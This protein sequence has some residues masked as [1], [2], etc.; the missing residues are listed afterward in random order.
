MPD[1]PASRPP[2]PGTS[3]EDRAYAVLVL[4][5]AAELEAHRDAWDTLAASATEP[6]PFYESWML[7]PAIAA[8]GEGR[9][10]EWVLVFGYGEQAPSI[11]PVLC[12]LFPLERRR[13]IGGAPV[14][15]RAGWRH[16]YCFSGVPLVRRG[17]ERA[18]VEAFLDE[19]ASRRGG[20][21]IVR[22][23]QWPADGALHAALFDALDRRGAATYVR[24]RAARAYLR[25]STDADAYFGDALVPKRRKEFGRLERRLAESGRVRF[26]ALSADGDVEAWIA[27]FVALEA[28]GWKGREGTAFAA[29]PADLAW[30]QAVARGGFARGRLEMLALRRDALAIAF[31]VNFLAADGAFGFK[32]AFD[33]AWGRY[34]PGVLLEIENVRRIHA[35]GGVQWMDSC[36]DPHHPM[37]NRL[38]SGRRVYEDFFFALRGGLAALVVSAMPLARCARGAFR[39]RK[40]PSDDGPRS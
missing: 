35:H 11:D 4:R 27:E 21:G 28:K 34:S 24:S 14:R 6:N 26:D 2:L 36:A 16:D 1:L 9:D 7:A 15:H 32:I 22:F 13:R 39:R 33:E 25:P 10:L 12:G 29:R 8:F 30:L 19:L 40:S 17:R 18:V 38:W 23:D 5:T 3:A 20:G 31:K 37:A